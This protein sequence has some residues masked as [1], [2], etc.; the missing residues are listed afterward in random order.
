MAVKNAE[1]SKIIL[2]VENGMGE[3][4]KPVYASRTFQHINP[5]LSDDDAYAIGEA[6][7]GLQTHTLGTVSRTDSAQLAAV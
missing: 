5:A 3:G 1:T 2:K 6:L 4:G 7:A